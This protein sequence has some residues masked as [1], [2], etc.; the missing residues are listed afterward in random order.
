MI[1][2]FDSHEYQILR[3]LIQQRIDYLRSINFG[4]E[5]RNDLAL[6]YEKIENAT[7]QDLSNQN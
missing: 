3:K 2:T 5:E 4:R 7:F 6:L 1:I